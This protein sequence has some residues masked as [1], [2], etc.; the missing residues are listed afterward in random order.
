[1]KKNP[2]PS[3]K[4]RF[5][6]SP[7]ERSFTLLE[8]IIALG[9]MVSLIMEVS[10]VQG[11]SINFSVFTKKSSRATWIAKAIMA[12]IEY[13]SRFYPAKE[14][15]SDPTLRERPVSESLCK[16]VPQ[17]DCNFTYTVLIDEFKLPI[18]DL[19]TGKKKKTDEDSQSGES[20]ED[21]MSAL[22]KDRVKDILGDDILKIAT[23]EVFWPEGSRRESV[24]LAYL[25]ANQQ[26]LDEYIETLPP[27][28]STA[29]C[30]GKFQYFDQKK[31]QCVVCKKGFETNQQRNNCVKCKPTDAECMN[32]AGAQPGNPAA[33][34]PPAQ[35][36][37]ETS[38]RDDDE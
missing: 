17:N 6:R 25:F 29:S 12:E 24:R 18:I 22:I 32:Q 19:L 2:D 36:G 8:T 9:L 33:E 15:K 35:P 34:G 23:V 13:K 10:T 28:V 16:K 30:D 3:L 26:S 4:N 37:Q 14:M 5:A 38:G 21:P 7:S 20:E 27:I 11:N 1:M 31:N